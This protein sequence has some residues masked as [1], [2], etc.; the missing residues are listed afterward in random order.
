MV[1]IGQSPK[2]SLNNVNGYSESMEKY[3]RKRFWSS[4]VN[5]T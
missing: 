4:V 2:K 1:V 3:V 5:F